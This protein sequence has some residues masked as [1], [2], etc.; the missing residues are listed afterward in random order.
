M[1]APVAMLV[2]I[3]KLCIINDKIRGYGANRLCV[4]GFEA[5]K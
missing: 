3:I 5:D 2:K 1:A 4:M